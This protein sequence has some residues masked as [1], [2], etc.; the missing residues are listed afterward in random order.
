VEEK[1]TSSSSSSSSA[2]GERGQGHAMTLT[3]IYILP[4]GNFCGLSAKN[5]QRYSQDRNGKLGKNWGERG[6]C[7]N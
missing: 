2:R 1:Q 7:P 4:K 6:K 3:K 5:N